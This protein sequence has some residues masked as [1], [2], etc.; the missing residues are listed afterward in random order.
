[1]KSQ[2]VGLSAGDVEVGTGVEGVECVLREEKNVGG[3][4]NC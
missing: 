3:G 1:M 2:G 4:E